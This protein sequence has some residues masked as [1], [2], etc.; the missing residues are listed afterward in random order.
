MINFDVPDTAEAYTHRIGRTGRAER[1]GDA[2]TLV[3][4]ED[5]EIVADVERVLGYRLVRNT[6]PGFR[7]DAP[8]PPQRPNAPDRTARDGQPARSNRPAAPQAERRDRTPPAQ[9]SRT[10]RPAR[11]ST[12]RPARTPFGTQGRN[13]AR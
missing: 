2:F 11:T 13:D 5:E 1:T 4:P 8:L 3:T 9:P 7:Y 10:N 6:L 12:G